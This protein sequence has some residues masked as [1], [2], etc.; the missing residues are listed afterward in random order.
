ML[1]V[2]G[3]TLDTIPAPVGPM[4]FGS[5]VI[6][7]AKLTSGI[8]TTY[9]SD[10]AI[11]DSTY[12]PVGGFLTLTNGSFMTV[13][14]SSFVICG[15]ANSVL[16]E[17]I[18][19]DNSSVNIASTVY[20][21]VLTRTLTGISVGDTIVLEVYGTLLNGATGAITWNFQV[22]VGSV[23][24]LDFQGNGSLPSHATNRYPLIG[25]FQI[26][27]SA[28]NV[29]RATGM[30]FQNASAPVAV[31]VASLLN[32]LGVWNFGT[33]DLTGTQVITFKIKSSVATATQTFTINNFYI[34]RK[35]RSN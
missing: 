6:N 29:W 8:L 34:R 12:W 11:P 28:T 33:N 30:L 15:N 24:V 35:D 18:N 10:F 4:D 1:N 7:N 17:S 25:Q 20:V 9:T 27:V 26:A 5:Q 23:A 21:P 31:N 13:P 3:E 22:N 32:N 19:A 16:V 14:S 2:T